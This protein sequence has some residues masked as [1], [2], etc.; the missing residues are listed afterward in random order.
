MRRAADG[1]LEARVAET[2]QQAIEALA[3]PELPL[4]VLL[5]F[6]L[7]DMDG[8]Q[9]VRRLRSDPR[10]RSLPVVVF[11]SVQDPRRIQQT[12][13]AGADAWVPKPND[14]AA[15]RETVRTLCQKWAGA[16]GNASA[17]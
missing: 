11:S 1:V 13:E 5:D 3:G 17:K 8:I 9:V 14:P 10:C 7:P 6:R 16:T 4:F 12:L 2:G 15:L